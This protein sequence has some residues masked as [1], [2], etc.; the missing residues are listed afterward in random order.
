MAREISSP[1][2]PIAYGK[3]NFFIDT[4]KG[5]HV[6]FF[7]QKISHTRSKQRILISCPGSDL[8]QNN[9]PDRLPDGIKIFQQINII[10]FIPD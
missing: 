4:G 10:E 3:G 7:K 6:Y 9:G 1:W 2:F 8:C 5:E